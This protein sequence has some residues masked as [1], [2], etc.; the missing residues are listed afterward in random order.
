MSAMIR[1]QTVVAYLRQTAPFMEIASR[2]RPF[3]TAP[4]RDVSKLGYEEI[5]R[6]DAWKDDNGHG[7][8]VLRCELLRPT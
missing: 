1:S 6:T 3:G 7:Q 2:C 5:P 4:T 8:Y